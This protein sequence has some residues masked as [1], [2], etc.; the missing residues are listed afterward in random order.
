LKFI[1]DEQ[2]VTSAF[3]P[4][5]TSENG[6][7]VNMLNVKQTSA[8][9]YVPGLGLAKP[10]EAVHVGQAV[11]GSKFSGGGGYGRRIA[12]KTPAENEEEENKALDDDLWTSE[13]PVKILE[14]QEWENGFEAKYP[15]LWE[16]QLGLEFQKQWEQDHQR[17]WEDE[18]LTIEELEERELEM[19]EVYE[20]WKESLYRGGCK[21]IESGKWLPDTQPAQL[22][23]GPHVTN[24][25]TMLKRRSSGTEY[26][27]PNG[28]REGEEADDNSLMKVP[29]HSVLNHL[30]V[31]PLSDK[32]VL[33][34]AVQSRYRKKVSYVPQLIS[35]HMK[36]CEFVFQFFTTVLYKS[37]DLPEENEKVAA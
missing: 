7:L 4:S 16:Q 3:L 20:D 12:G 6:V 5:G 28:L 18:S 23:S 21:R 26:D 15:V 8:L 30:L 17:D 25:K 19:K 24:T 33:P 11:T 32:R 14:F 35:I 13:I 10:A 1:R 37:I 2:Y 36:T 9:P 29:V 27:G 31:Q 22:R 34:L